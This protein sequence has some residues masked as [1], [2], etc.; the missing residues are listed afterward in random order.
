MG[1]D[2]EAKDRLT[3]THIIRR[4]LRK[5][6]RNSEVLVLPVLATASV[7]PFGRLF[8][9]NRYLLLAA[10]AA[11][12]AT[13]VPSLVSPR[14]PL[15]AAIVV[16][17]VAELAYLG[18]FVVHSFA[19][20][21]LW[22][23]I[24][25]TW[26]SLLTSSLPAVSSSP[27]VVLPVVLAGA[28]T[29]I[30]VEISY[31]TGWKVGPVLA[32][33]GA[34]VVALLFTGKLHMPGLL[35]VTLIV[36]LV[37]LTVFLRVHDP[38]SSAQQSASFLPTRGPRAG[39]AFGLPSL[40]VV[41]VAAVALGSVLPLSSSGRR[42]DLREHY[43]P[44]LQI[45]DGISP[46]AELRSQVNSKSNTPLFTVRFTGIPD[47]MKIDRV[48]I[49]TLDVYDGSVWGT[50]ASFALVGHE[51][52]V[53][54][55][56]V[57][58]GPIIHQQYQV[59]TYQSSF[60]P[61]LSAPIRA[62]GKG[63]AFDRVSGTLAV[64][65]PPPAGFRYSVDSEV[66]AQN[67]AATEPVKAGNDPAFSVLAL[68]PPQGWPESIVRFANGITG[69][70]PYATLQAVANE[71]RSSAFGYN[72]Q[73]RPGHS[74]GALSAFLAAPSG[75]SDITTSRV[76]YAEQFAAAFAVIARIKGFPSRVVV[77]YR[78]DAT[79]AAKGETIAVLPR[80][81]HAWAEVDL[82]GIGW[83]SFDP[84]N[85]TPR[86]STVP[87][88]TPP[89][90][91]PPPVGVTGGNHA[92][93]NANP[94]GAGTKHHHQ[95]YWWIVVVV[96]LFLLLPFVVVA[97]KVLRRRRRATRGSPAARIVGAWKETRDGLRTHGA[98]IARSM[99]VDEAVSACRDTVGDDAATRL[100]TFGP[101]LNTALYAPFEPSEEAATDAWE[102]EESLRSL[103]SE[104]SSVRR[105]V[106]AAV[107]P[108][109]LIR[110]GGSEH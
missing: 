83:V 38:D 34:F 1:E 94:S 33:L 102:A 12:I 25:G 68:P 89:P 47:G 75:A 110:T 43:N 18:G 103:L 85:T 49:A 101:V 61:A 90:P 80:Q 91:A 17:I 6:R 98:P 87:P 62:S 53:G 10:G 40:A 9:D 7:A 19:P 11:I 4:I 56:G 46:L 97:A 71:L 3:M 15:P 58:V 36:V 39:V 30:G 2:V 99:T 13:L 105:R 50:D 14:W 70:T 27:Y 23:A 84:T 72:T 66:P 109:P 104:Q 64:S 37:L 41:A 95:P 54:P 74:L 67:L 35:Q 28:A 16:S 96:V 57:K 92:Q 107:D 60:L 79:A 76:G 26:S 108:R 93:T 78:V 82:N 29:Y 59:G 73:A 86:D 42:F 65:S 63:L 55:S 24:T 32:P 81:M 21:A 22:N 51:L 44:P 48:P 20:G 77:G 69:K 45:S 88:V 8:A 100:A 106:L 5:L 52:P 31:R